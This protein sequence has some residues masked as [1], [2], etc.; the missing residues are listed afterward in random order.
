MGTAQASDYLENFIIDHLFRTRSWTKPAAL[1]L[2]L[3]TAAPSDAGGGTEVT[4]G[5]YARVSVPP[6]DTNWQATQGG[7]SGNSSGAGGQTSNVNLIQFPTP[8]AN[9]GTVTHLGLLDAASGGNLLI[10]DVLSSPVTVLLGGPAPS[11]PA[12]ALKITV[13]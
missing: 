10:W 9:W 8:T 4:G 3:Y 7:S 13:S 2:A 11:F 1:Y 12:G 5:A 6:L